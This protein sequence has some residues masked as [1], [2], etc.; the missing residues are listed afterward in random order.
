M[1]RYPWCY[2]VKLVSFSG[3]R[4][5]IRSDP[6]Q[7]FYSWIRIQVNSTRILNHTLIFSV[8][9]SII[10]TYIERKKLRGNFVRSDPDPV[11]P[12]VGSGS[13]FFLDGRFRI[14]FFPLQSDLYPDSVLNPSHIHPDL[15]PCSNHYKYKRMSYINSMVLKQRELIFG[16]IPSDSEASEP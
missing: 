8:N 6:D 13:S 10:L 14:Q 9:I 4:I 7:F 3:L 1:R 11:F 5:R 16:S 15:Q 2:N 12:R